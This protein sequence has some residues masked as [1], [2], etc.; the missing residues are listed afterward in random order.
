MTWWGL[1]LKGVWWSA[2]TL[3][4]P[5]VLVV[6]SRDIMFNYTFEERR[7]EYEHSIEQTHDTEV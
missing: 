4:R 7:T 1:I 2:P 6:L 5:K 3:T